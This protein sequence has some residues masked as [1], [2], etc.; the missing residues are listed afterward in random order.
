MRI[1]MVVYV[2]VQLKAFSGYSTVVRVSVY[3]MRVLLKIMN[4]YRLRVK[5]F[6]WKMV[7]KM[8]F[9]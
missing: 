3:A 8:V 7:V 6:S 4:D 9:V 5:E 2:S 1:V